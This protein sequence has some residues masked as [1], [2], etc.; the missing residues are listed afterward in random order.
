MPPA[1]QH[2]RGRE[3]DR[4]RRLQE[5]QWSDEQVS[6]LSRAQQRTYGAVQASMNMVA[7]HC[8]IPT[9]LAT[10]CVVTALTT[11]SAPSVSAV[12]QIR[13]LE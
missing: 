9:E 3:A 6:W 13:W 10:R 7:R 2:N 1:S 5:Y 4:A 8:R 11:V 12:G